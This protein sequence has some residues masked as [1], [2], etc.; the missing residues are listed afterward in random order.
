[1]SVALGT[2]NMD[3]I[4]SG[5]EKRLG[6]GGKEYTDEKGRKYEDGKSR[7]SKVILTH[8]TQHTHKKS[9][10]VERKEEGMLELVEADADETVFAGRKGCSYFLF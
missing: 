2:K 3:C 5:I 9:T 8:T 1:M 6:R 10:A 4:S 7:T